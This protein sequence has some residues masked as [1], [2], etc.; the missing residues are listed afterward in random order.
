ML[1]SSV[2][3]FDILKELIRTNRIKYLGWLLFSEG[4]GKYISALKTSLIPS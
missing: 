3:K 1:A 4:V 2:T